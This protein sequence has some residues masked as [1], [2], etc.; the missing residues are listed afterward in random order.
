MRKTI[1]GELQQLLLADTNIFVTSPGA[2][3]ITEDVG[4]A[5]AGTPNLAKLWHHAYRKELVHE[6]ERTH[7]PHQDS[8]NTTDKCFHN[9]VLLLQLRGTHH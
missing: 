6:E 3:D 8:K 1:S 5:V 9:L 7:S 4:I 2:L